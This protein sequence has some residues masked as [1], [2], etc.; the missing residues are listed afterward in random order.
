MIQNQNS[1]TEPIF[2]SVKPKQS[3]PQITKN[4]KPSMVRKLVSILTGKSV[5]VFIDGSNLYYTMQ[6]SGKRFN[7]LHFYKWLQQ[8]SK[9]K[10]VHYYTAFDPEDPKQTDFLDE[11]ENA[12]YKIH[13]KP[14]RWVIDHHKGNMDVEL[15]VDAMFLCPEYE[16]MILISGDG[17]FSYLCQT[18][19]KLD[20]QTIIMSLGGYTAQELHESAANFFF[21]ERIESV[22]K[23]R[24]IRKNDLPSP[25]KEPK[26]KLDKFK[27]K[28]TLESSI[29]E[30]KKQKPKPKLR[31]AEVKKESENQNLNQKPII[32]I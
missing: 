29:L 8:K 28:N 14:V 27:T 26:L 2:R 12:G 15:A 19:E 22:W 17:D 23:S 20:K 31:L 3:K 24:L 30:T 6:N 21:L 1:Q 16:V 4:K 13:K 11:L 32:H 7:F 25:K 9:L 10:D 5:A 18:L